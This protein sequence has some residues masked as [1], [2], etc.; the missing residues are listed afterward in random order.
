[1]SLTFPLLVCP[2]VVLV[3]VEVAFPISTHEL[4]RLSREE[5]DGRINYGGSRW[6]GNTNASG[7]SKN[8]LENSSCTTARRRRGLLLLLSAKCS[9]MRKKCNFEEVAYTIFSNGASPVTSQ[10]AG[11]FGEEKKVIFF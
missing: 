3:V 4:R 9:K 2:P 8:T 11:F 10:G 1:M 7:N 5:S 6:P